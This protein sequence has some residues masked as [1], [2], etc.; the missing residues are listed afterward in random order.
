MPIVQAQTQPSYHDLFNVIKQ[1]SI[2]EL[3]QFVSQ[4]IELQMDKTPTLDLD[5]EVIESAINGT[6][7]LLIINKKK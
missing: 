7:E 3:N 5:D 1:L 6:L 2:V 4:I